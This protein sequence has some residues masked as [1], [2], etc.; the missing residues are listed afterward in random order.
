MMM[1]KQKL[2]LGWSTFCMPI[3]HLLYYEYICCVISKNIF[4]S[5]EYVPM[6]IK[7]ENFWCYVHKFACKLIKLSHKMCFKYDEW[8][9]YF[10]PL[11]CC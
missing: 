10:F 5:S 1:M 4:G 8:N 3:W 2:E 6:N 11:D 7:V 9:L